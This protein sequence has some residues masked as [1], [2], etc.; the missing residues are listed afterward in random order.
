LSVKREGEN[1]T[2]YFELCNLFREDFDEINRIGTFD[3][4]L[5]NKDTMILEIPYWSWKHKLSEVRARI[6]SISSDYP[7]IWPLLRDEFEYCHALIGSR[8]FSITP[9]YPLLDKFSS[10]DRCPRRVYMS[11]TLAN[12][13][14]IIR[15]FDADA[16]SVSNPIAPKSL[17]GVGE[18]MIL[19]PALMKLDHNQILDFTKY[20][21]R[22]IS[23]RAGVLILVPS[24]RALN[25][26]SDVA[27]IP[28]R[29]EDVDR[30]IQELTAT[31]R[32]A[33]ALS[34][35]YDGLDLPRDSCR[36]VT[37]QPCPLN[38]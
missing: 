2:L 4:I 24:N 32:R 29:S 8:S 30:F 26:W 14:S 38:H 10:F 21:I 6:S 5:A 20:M 27:E 37:I 22:E 34:N 11:A 28:S 31:S 16:L 17:A 19:A 1:E 18:R 7:F 15:T 33:Y 3:D 23:E 9:L 12:D 25:K 13:S 36:L 35:R